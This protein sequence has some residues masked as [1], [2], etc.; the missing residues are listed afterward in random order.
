MDY[1]REI[2]MAF[3]TA[4][5]LQNVMFSRGLGMSKHALIVSGP[6][7]VFP[8]GFALTAVTICS[9]LL[10][11]PFIKLLRERELFVTQPALRYLV[12]LGGV[13]M[14]YLLVYWVSKHFLP[15]C[16]YHIRGCLQSAAFNCAVLGS[17]LI[18]YSGNYGLLKTAGFAAGSGLGYMLALLMLSEGR[19][20][21]LLADIP[22]AFRGLPI[23]LLYTGIF[24]LAVYGLVGHQLPT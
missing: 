22:R 8:I 11:W 24:A 15:R 19:R 9:S 5:V 21:I 13:C 17:I 20:R 4:A 18:A 6:R 2:I 16:Y 10:A 23:M 12:A 1:L 14:A 3:F 7:R